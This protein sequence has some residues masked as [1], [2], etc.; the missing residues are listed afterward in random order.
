VAVF[1]D[2]KDVRNICLPANWSINADN[3]CAA[4]FKKVLDMITETP[5]RIVCD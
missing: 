1:F 5:V 3:L 4:I 2:D